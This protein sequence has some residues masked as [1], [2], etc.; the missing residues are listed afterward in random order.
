MSRPTNVR[1]LLTGLLL[2]GMAGVAGACGT[3]DGTSTRLSGRSPLEHFQ[4]GDPVAPTPEAVGAGLLLM[5]GGDHD[6]DA[7]QWFLQRAGHGHIVVLRASMST[8]VA[9]EIYRRFRGAVSVDTF[10]FHGRRAARDPVMLDCLAAADGIFIAGGDQSRYTAFWKN[11]DVARLIDAHVAAGKP[12]AGT[13]AGLAILGEYLFSA[14]TPAVVTSD[15]ALADPK[16]RDITIDTDFL[17]LDV[18]KG[19]FTDSHFDKRRRLGR[20]VAFLTRANEMAARKG[21]KIEGLGIDEDTAL[22]VLPDGDARV[23]SA[24]AL[25]GAAWVHDVEGTARKGRPLETGSLRVTYLGTQSRFN[26]RDH[27]AR[28]V[29]E[30]RVFRVLD[31]QLHPR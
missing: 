10:V 7:M 1:S 25:A 27:V 14:R 9:D 31:G 12:L 3:V 6:P 15:L 24:D 16:G 28:D 2:L 18:L 17:H 30:E 11:T 8:D 26:L 21:D 29:R 4:I 23:Y 19:Y 13:S 5:G 22:A 20:L